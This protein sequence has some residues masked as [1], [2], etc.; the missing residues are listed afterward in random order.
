MILQNILSFI[1]LT[2]SCFLFLSTVL[3]LATEY[4]K[5]N[6]K[7]LDTVSAIIAFII[8]MFLTYIT[9]R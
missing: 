5:S 4:K 8:C 2:F 7:I 1:G 6:D 9:I 3:Y